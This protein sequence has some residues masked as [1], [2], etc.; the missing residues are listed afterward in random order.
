MAARAVDVLRA[1]GPIDVKSIHRDALLRWLVF[2]PVLIAFLLRWVVP[3]LTAHLVARLG[4]DLTPYY[5]LIMS[6]MLLV[7]PGLCGM[8]IGFL[9]LDQR[10]DETLTALQVTPLTLRGYFAYRVAIPML[11]SVVL[12]MVIFPLSALVE[13]GLWP[14]FLATVLAAPMAP[15]YALFL[16]AFA[17]NKVQGFALAKAVSAVL[18]PPGLA[19]FISSSWQI[20]FGVF[21][22]YWPMKFYWVVHTHAKAAWLYLLV[23]LVYQMLLLVLLLRRFDRVMHR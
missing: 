8:V 5:P 12:T 20:A 2:I 23:G 10:D 7:L 4:F 15:I 1:L 16:A 13:I 9:L 17:G 14:L 21:P 3:W 6:M 18:W 19:Y 11:I 22:T